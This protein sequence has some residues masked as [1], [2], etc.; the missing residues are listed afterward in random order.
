VGGIFLFSGFTKL[1]LPPE[2]FVQILQSYQVIPE[3]LITPLSFLLPGIELLCGSCL[4]LGFFIRAASIAI[5]LQ[6]F[7]FIALMSLVI[8]SGIEL[9]DCGCFGA[10]GIQE[11]PGQVIIRDVVL[12]IISLVLL[13]TK[14]HIYTLDNLFQEH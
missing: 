11:T 13:I 4:L 9:E 14:K 10:L 12:L 6:L 7:I 8:I 5:A 3:I 1:L 2:E